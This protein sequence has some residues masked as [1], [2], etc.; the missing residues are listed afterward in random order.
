MKDYN[1][2][3]GAE[4]A[5]RLLA[6]RETEDIKRYKFPS[7]KTMQERYEKI[8]ASFL[9]AEELSRKLPKGHPFNFH[10]E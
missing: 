3:E 8:Q 6:E 2:G 10:R 7:I 9:R 5:R 1:A 4:K